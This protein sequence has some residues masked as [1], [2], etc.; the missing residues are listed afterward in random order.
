MSKNIPEG[1]RK[2]GT[3]EVEITDLSHQG[4]GVAHVSNYPLFINNALPGEKVKVKITH[5]GK[6]IGHG[7]AVEIIEK[8]PQRVEIIDDKHT[9]NGTMPLQ[10]LAYPEQLKFKQQQVQKLLSKVGHLEDV[11]VF[12]TIGMAHPYDYRN[13][14]QIPV[15][16][17]DGKL[18]TGFYKKRT[19]DLIPIED[20]VIQAP[21]IDQAIIT[22]RDILR[23]YGVEAY[24]E[25][26]HS[27]D[28]RHIVVRRGHFT[29]EMMIVLVTCS[30]LLPHLQNIVADIQQEI[31]EVVSIVQNINSDKTNVILGKQSMVLFGQDYYVDELMGHT[32]KISHQSFYQVNSVQTEKLYQ[33]AVDY[34]DLSNDDIVV[35]AYSGIG[36]MTLALAE[37]AD[38][39]Y[40]VEIV[41]EAIA[42]AILNAEENEI[43][44][45]TFEAADAGDW[46]VN[47]AK[48]NMQVDVVV[49]DPP[50]KG[51][52]EDFINAVLKMQPEKMVYVSCNPNTLAR[53]LKMLHEGGYTVEKVQPV[54]MFPQTYHIE[55]VTLL[56]KER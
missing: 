21:E 9:Q 29:G 56:V 37:E 55:S 6:R 32:F 20:F 34:A 15:R 49:V 1:L 48:N 10:H 11:P 47:Q 19:H 31:P 45:V 50:R 41:P 8:S 7:D 14:A 22:V 51:L 54:D 38:K 53:D 25:N 33:T 39:V 3:Y 26:E 36:T 23:K 13:K 30:M 35:D 40:G 46:L 18:T 17:I 42:D 24:D 44:N 2:N 27:G 52:S 12:E 5:L 43:K 28:I 4:L 16:E